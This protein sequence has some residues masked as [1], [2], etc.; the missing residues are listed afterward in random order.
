MKRITTIYLI[1]IIFFGGVFNSIQA[2]ENSKG[3]K[4]KIGLVLSGGGAKGLAH[5]G[6]LKKLEKAG[7]QV[8]YIGGTSMGAIVGAL[9]ASGY[10]ATELDSLFNAVNFNNLIQDN[11]PRSAKTFYAKED[12]ERYALT[13][14][15]N[16]FKLSIPQ[17]ISGGQ[18]VYNELVRLLFHV[19]DIQDFKKLPIPFLCMATDVETGEAILLDKG[20][21]PGAIM[22][23]GSFPSLFEPAEI[24]GRILIDGGVVNNYPVDEV[25]AMGADYI[26]GVDVQD[27]LADRESLQS[28]TEI[29]LQINNYRTVEDTYEKLQRTDL[30]I[31]PDIKGFSVIDF[32]PTKTLIERGEIA[33]DIHADE[34]KRLGQLQSKPFTKKRAIGVMDS[35]VINRLIISGNERFTRRYIK[36][37]LRFNLGEKIPFD[38]LTTGISNL[39]ATGNFKTLRYQLASNG[40]GT[41]LVL[42]IKEDPDRMFLKLAAHFDDLYRTGALINISRKNLLSK[43][44]VASLDFIIGDNVRY[45]FEYYVDRGSNWSFGFN[46][47][48]NTF[49]EE[50]DFGVIQ[51]NFNVVEDP[52]VGDINLDVTDFT[53][54]LYIQR[55]VQK[56]FALSLG[57]EQ[58]LIRYSTRTLTPLVEEELNTEELLDDRTFFED[59]NYY[60]AYGELALDTY[61]DKYFP[62]KGVRFQGDFHFYLLSSD[63]NDNFQQFA[64]GKASLGTVF[65]I[66]SRLS[67]NLVAEGGFK[68]GLSPITTFDFVLG[69]YGND[70]INNFTPFFGYDFLSL[71][72]NS[73]VKALSR[74]DYEFAKKNHAILSLNV[75]NVDDDI[76][77][78]GEWF[79]SPSFSGLGVG[80]G[81]ESFIGPVQIFYSYSPEIRQN[82]FFFSVGF[83]F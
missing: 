41:D 37:K 38:R 10:S 8:D 23:S 39:A 35:L 56:K 45:N 52:N 79:T 31:R 6:V 2:Q 11:V 67:L 78:T 51:S 18:N 75:A 83:W 43:D 68:L 74:L 19:R 50:I 29:L 59:S 17:S 81:L 42:D 57:I 73:F 3:A 1:I 62:T 61:D 48:F 58:K 33:A 25:I 49:E 54:Q 24:E 14:P 7:I 69:G 40:V 21:L 16:N 63:F 53:N 66:A 4:P 47:R 55:V 72:G 27:A 65:P 32:S 76:F 22:A 70:L 71:P 36:G 26:I 64:I 20:Y 9:Y 34:F 44:D 13:L 60:S 12:S 46:S 30:Y 28:A 5:I 82:I 80:Y 15:F 77:R